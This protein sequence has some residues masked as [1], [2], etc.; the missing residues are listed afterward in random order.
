MNNNNIHAE[1]GLLNDISAAAFFNVKKR[2]IRLW[3]T[4]QGLPHI[5]VT[6]RIIRY[7]MADLQSWM[8]K[9]CYELK[10]GQ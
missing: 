8:D 9:R 7:R 5:R 10:G 2:T 1:N 3:R 6:S 4:S